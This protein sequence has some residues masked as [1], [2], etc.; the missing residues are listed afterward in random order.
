MEEKKALYDQAMALLEG[1]NVYLKDD[2]QL[3]TINVKMAGVI[4]DLNDIRIKNLTG[5]S[6]NAEEAK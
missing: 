4:K 2:P 3:P 1:C 6:P 5:F